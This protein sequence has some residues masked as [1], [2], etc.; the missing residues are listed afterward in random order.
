[1]P[2]QQSHESSNSEMQY[3]DLDLESSESTISQSP[4]ALNDAPMAG[5]GGSSSGHGTSDS[6][7][8]SI[9]HSNSHLNQ[10]HQPVTWNIPASNGN[11]SA[12]PFASQHQLH[13]P[14]NNNNNSTPNA[15]LPN[16]HCNSSSTVYKKVDFVKTKAFNEMRV[17][18]DFY[19][20]GPN[21]RDVNR[22]DN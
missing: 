11:A 13:H 14:N 8:A 9:S 21:V 2:G 7:L 17:N 19:R 22:V 18:R 4:R 3:L 15:N 12:D 20:Y 16:G 6:S 5:G 10:Q 1:M